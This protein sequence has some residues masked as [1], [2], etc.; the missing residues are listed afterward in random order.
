[1]SHFA[2]SAH[3]DG[4]RRAGRAWDRQAA[5]V[6]AGDLTDE[7]LE[8]LRGDPNITITP[9]AP[10]GVPAAGAAAPVSSGDLDA[11]LR[12]MAVA[13]FRMHLIRAAMRTLDP[14][15]PD[16]FTK[17]GPPE[18]AALREVTGLSSISAAERDDCW[19]REQAC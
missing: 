10:E 14:G 19:E 8:Q 3:R 11:V 1:M 16:H 13:D 18:V 6:A 7:Q 15:N 4:F 12:G 9:C 2:I 5:I 17:S